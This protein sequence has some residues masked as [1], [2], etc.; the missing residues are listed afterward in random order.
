MLPYR[1]RK[2]LVR[3]SNRSGGDLSVLLAESPLATVVLDTFGEIRAANRIFSQYAYPSPAVVGRHI[4][5][6]VHPDD[7]GAFNATLA[8]AMLAP[9]VARTVEIRFATAAPPAVD[10]IATIICHPRG[11][12]MHVPRCV[13][14]FTDI[15]DRKRREAEIVTRESRWN[16]ALTGSASGVWDMFPQT[17][18]MFYS[19]TWRAIR[20]IRPGGPIPPDT[21]SWL[22]IVH[23]D[24]R[25]HVIYCIE[26]QNSGDPDYNTFEYRE[27]H[28][29]G[30]WIWIECRGA[31]VE[32]DADGVPVRIIGTDTDVTDRKT[33][34]ENHMQLARRLD[35]ALD[36]SKIGV[37]ETN[38]EKRSTHW[39]DRLV[40]IYGLEGSG[41]EIASGAWEA[42]VH[43][44]DK[45]HAVFHIQ[46]AIAEG[47]NAVSEF[48]IIRPADGAVR[49]IRSRACTYEDHNGCR[50]LLGVNWD[51]TDDV[52][53]RQELE[54]TRILTEARNLELE[55]AKARI[56]HIAL[57]DYLT[58]L[59]NRRYL[60][61]MLD[62]FDP[63]IG[64]QCSGIAILHLDLDRFKQIND[65]LGHSA[66]DAMLRHAAKVLTSNIRP[67]DF[68][69]RIG[70]DEFVLL[71]QFDGSLSKLSRLAERIIHE[72]RKPVRYEGHECRFGASIGIACAKGADIDGRQVLLNADIA[73]YNAKNRGRNRYEFFSPE[74]HR[75]LIDAKRLADE[76]LSGLERDEF[77]PYYQ[78]QFDAVSLDIVGVETLARWQHPVRGVLTP[79]KF[80]ALAGE[81][82]VV[83]AIDG[84]ILGK[85]LADFDRWTA[86]GLCIP[87]LSVNVSARRL[88]DPGLQ[89]TLESLPIRP[90][91]LSFELLESIFLDD[92][93]AQARKNLALLD[94]LGIDIEIDDFGSGHASI[95]SLLRL[96]PRTLKIDRELIR[97][98]TVS[99][100]QRKLVGS[101]IEIGRSLN[102]AVLAE[103]VETAEHATALRILGCDTLQGFGLARPL[104][105]EN[106]EAFVCGQSWRQIA[107]RP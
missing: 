4:T 11:P 29:D 42:F 71:A 90:G 18:A 34:E 107:I 96:N 98:V 40:A 47:I 59:P 33:S 73:L 32:W 25:Q 88:H 44:D 35:L 27:R 49:H 65:T 58:G 19:D 54:R 30:H 94:R 105:F 67:G 78:F 24:D 3:S 70:G 93:N 61:E 86:M 51:V 79:D 63:K 38:L 95:V 80:L 85:A 56:E 10:V 37:F 26:R 69:A 97:E 9:G 31:C 6:L 55:V 46:Q 28:I 14:Q 2:P 41:R 91:T 89:E 82:D 92:L 45:Q 62:G 74:A 84:V 22:E 12:G 43:P 36:T 57:H 77:V 13:A 52:L 104:A 100:E 50:K 76:I 53:T 5:D 102:I 15:T 81:L 1:T 23:P 106:I 21:Q 101:I 66:G 20:G 8:A 68:V 72:L 99:E 75:Q 87:K 64:G 60:D 16:Y 103:G 17:G 39:D 83:S 48:R 7:A